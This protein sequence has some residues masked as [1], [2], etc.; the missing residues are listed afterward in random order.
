MRIVWC[1][2]WVRGGGLDACGRRMVTDVSLDAAGRKRRIC[3]APVV[4]I[5]SSSQL[6]LVAQ[7]ADRKSTGYTTSVAG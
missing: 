7:V 4:G 1:C 2:S 5:D 6:Y 3:T